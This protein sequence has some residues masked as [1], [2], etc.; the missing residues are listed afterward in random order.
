[1]FNVVPLHLMN[2]MGENCGVFHLCGFRL[3][4]LL[5]Y[6]LLIVICFCLSFSLICFSS[7]LLSIVLSLG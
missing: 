7:D 5:F 1:M 4:V 3:S 2:L 6:N